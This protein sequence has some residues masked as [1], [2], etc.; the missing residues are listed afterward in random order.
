MPG[1][2]GYQLRRAKRVGEGAWRTKKRY[3]KEG[4]ITCGRLYLASCAMAAGTGVTR[5]SRIMM[6]LLTLAGVPVISPLIAEGVIRPEDVPVQTTHCQH[7][8]HTLCDKDGFQGCSG[9]ET[10][11]KWQEPDKKNHCF[12]LW[13]NSSE[14]RVEITFK[15]CWSNDQSCTDEC[16]S[17]Q[18]VSS[19]KGEKN[20]IFCCCNGNRCNQNFSWEPAE[21]VSTTKPPS[22]EVDNKDAMVQTVLWTLGT[23]VTL[24]VIVALLFYLYRRRKMANFL[25]IPTVESTALA[26]PSP[27]MGLRPI[28]LREIKARGRFGAVWKAQLHSDIVAVKIFPVQDKQSW[29]VEKEVYSL[30]QMSHENILQFIGA[31][32]RGDNLQAEYWLITAYHD[33]GSLCDY[34]KANLVTWAELCKIGESMA[35]GLMYVHEEQQATKCEALKPSIA[36]R[37]FKSK[38]VLLKN[39]LSAC[40]ADFGLALVF[41]PGQP[42]G[43]T[44]GQVGTR[45]YMAPEV[46]E[47]AINFQRDAFLRIDMYA[48]GLVLWEILSRCSNQ[49]GPV[50]EYHL[51]FEEEVGQHPTLD[52]MQECV[53]AQKARPAIRD[54]WRKNPGMMALVD[55]MEECWDHDAEARLSASCVVERLAVYTRNQHFSPTSNPHKESSI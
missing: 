48:C 53:V 45:R 39:D 35:R 27:P 52:D 51:P 34:L 25:E 26:P 7:Y 19:L 32:K 46:L 4:N 31:E 5:L 33:R 1:L 11:P 28:Q 50:P 55:T 40:I 14:G 13:T 47:G 44:H 42:T 15:G 21:D 6:W 37:D 49:E 3:R 16:V 2:T 18:A 24:V 22:V 38:N 17:K 10:C 29:Q 20:H 36:H 9:I 54:C 41:H 12:V 8:N 30:P 43:D 23:L